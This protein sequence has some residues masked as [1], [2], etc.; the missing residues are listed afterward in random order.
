MSDGLG[1]GTANVVGGW[2]IST[3]FAALLALN[4]GWA[5]NLE[6]R[7]I[8]LGMRW[9]VALFGPVKSSETQADATPIVFVDIDEPGCELLASA[10]ERCRTA[11]VADPELL[12][13]LGW[14]LA[15]SGARLIVL[16]VLLPARGAAGGAP[17][18]AVAAWS[19]GEGPPVLAALPSA[20]GHGRR[21]VVEPE[22]FARL[23]T[24]R[25][26]AAPALVWTDT[27]G[28]SIVRSYP[29]SAEIV[30][31]E[32]DGLPVRMT[33]LPFAA[34]ARLRGDTPALQ[35]DRS[36]DRTFFSL[37]TMVDARAR[38]SADYVG[39]YERRALSAMLGDPDCAAC[40]PSISVAGLEGQLVIVGS[41]APAADDL[42]MTPLGV[43]SG[44]EIIAN[45]IRAEEL[46]AE[47]RRPGPLAGLW[48]KVVETAPAAILAIAS[49]VA[50]SWVQTRSG[51][52][53][54]ARIGT[55][56]LIS[57]I[58]G[59]G[60]ALALVLALHAAMAA[61]VGSYEEGRPVDLLIP[62]LSVFLGGFIEVAA[63]VTGT[64]SETTSGWFRRCF[65]SIAQMKEVQ[66]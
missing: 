37:P 38:F 62:T 25:L 52:S 54:P 45:V 46:F 51:P 47:Q 23:T 3:L 15:K 33:T 30:T 35:A 26:S 2:L 43:M 36:G 29:R 53:L 63:L 24:G 8:D 61:F 34:S 65:K 18:A 64:V 11:G 5:V 9:G 31:T 50:I 13:N 41:T 44:A 48:A 19:E 6:Q 28:G 21:I 27:E 59:A 12:E 14:A 60:L 4:I 1:S 39:V 22:T 56:A 58:Y 32:G 40:P 7:G 55:G 49:C 16:D 17:D 66:E 57:L 10:P 20:D 42:H